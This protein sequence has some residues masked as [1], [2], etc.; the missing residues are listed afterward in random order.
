MDAQMGTVLVHGIREAYG[1]YAKKEHIS[2]VKIVSHWLLYSFIMFH[3]MSW[4]YL[5]LR[6]HLE[7]ITMFATATAI[8]GLDHLIDDDSFIIHWFLDDQV[9]GVEHI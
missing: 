6:L 4:F 2:I 7:N 3:D 9:L 1:R 5:L 8:Y